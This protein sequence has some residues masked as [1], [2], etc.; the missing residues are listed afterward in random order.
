MGGTEHQEL[1]TIRPGLV[2]SPRAGRDAHHV[3]LLDLDDLVVELHPAAPAHHQVEL[4]LLSM[5]MPVGEA[6]AGRDA[7]IA[8]AAV[9]EPERLAG[10]AELEVRRAVE[11]GSE[12]LQ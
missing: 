1:E 4:F 3:P 6:I 10:N 5:R 9:L 11:V 12:V 7:L 8:K 2:A